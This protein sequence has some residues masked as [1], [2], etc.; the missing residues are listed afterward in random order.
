MPS[1]K[2]S[3]LTRSVFQRIEERVMKMERRVPCQP[4]IVYEGRFK[5]MRLWIC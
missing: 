2:G 3:L 1:I 4:F 5:A